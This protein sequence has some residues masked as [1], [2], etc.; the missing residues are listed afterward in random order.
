MIPAKIWTEP[1][2]RHL[3]RKYNRAI[4][5]RILTPVMAPVY[6]EKPLKT[7]IIRVDMYGNPIQPQRYNDGNM[8]LGQVYR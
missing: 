7:R 8:T 1:E 5:G 6:H 3:T 2:E 4:M